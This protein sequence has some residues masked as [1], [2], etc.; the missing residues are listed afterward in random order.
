MVRPPPWA[1]CYWDNSGALLQSSHW[2]FSHAPSSEATVSQDPEERQLDAVTTLARAPVTMTVREA[3]SH[4]TRGRKGAGAYETRPPLAPAFRAGFVL[5]GGS[6]AP[7][8]KTSAPLKPK[9]GKSSFDPSVLCPQL[10]A[11]LPASVSA[12]EVSQ[13]PMASAHEHTTVTTRSRLSNRV[14]PLV[15]RTPLPGLRMRM[16]SAKD[17]HYREEDDRAGAHSRE[18]RPASGD[19]SVAPW[20]NIG[21]PPHSGAPPARVLDLSACSHVSES[22][23]GLLSGEEEE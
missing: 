17:T 11:L 20:P 3:L 1:D 2:Q 6:R 12:A 16:R 15:S 10:H 5:L 23:P 22:Y 8:P 13:Q 19:A 4:A 18:A 9:G 21:H 14:A 7:P